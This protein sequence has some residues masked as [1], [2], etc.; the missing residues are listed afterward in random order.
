LIY[1]QHIINPNEITDKYLYLLKGC[2]KILLYWTLNELLKDESTGLNKNHKISIEVGNDDINSIHKLIDYYK[3][4]GFTPICNLLPFEFGYPMQTT[5]ENVISSIDIN[6]SIK[7]SN[8]SNAGSFY[9]FLQTQTI[10]IST[11]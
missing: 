11:V 1:Q 3:S 8:E 10:D 7:E 4:I 5:I 6:N 2:G 9:S